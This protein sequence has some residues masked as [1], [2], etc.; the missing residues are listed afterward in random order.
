MAIDLLLACLHHLVVFSLVTIPAVEL[1]LMRG[2]VG[3]TR[4]A[5][6]ARLDAL[7]GLLA[8]AILAIGFGRVYGGAKGAAFYL[9]NPVFWAK[10]AFFALAGLASAAPT[11]RILRWKKAMAREPGFAVPDA[12]LASTRRWLTAELALFVPIPLL[13]A[14]M[15]RAVGLG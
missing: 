1:A 8:M 5:H 2:Q 6:L 7:Y 4:I 14:A 12:D 3:A 15:A 11:V 9:H 10:L 13:A